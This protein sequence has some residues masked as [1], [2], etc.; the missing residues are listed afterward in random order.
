[1]VGEIFPARV[2]DMIVRCLECGDG[3]LEGSCW[4]VL[5]DLVACISGAGIPVVP[6]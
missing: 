3:V 6:L 2:P 4:T 5:V 1:M